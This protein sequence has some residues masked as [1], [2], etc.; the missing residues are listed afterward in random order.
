MPGRDQNSVEDTSELFELIGFLR[1]HGVKA[2]IVFIHHLAKTGQVR[3]STN[4]EAEVD[5]VLGVQ[6]DKTGNVWL[7]IRRARSMDEEIDY[8][9]QF[10][11]RYLGETKQGHKLHAPVVRLVNDAPQK[12]GVSAAMAKRYSDAMDALVKLGVGAHSLE[13]IVLAL[14]NVISVPAPS[15]KQRKNYRTRAVQDAIDS[16]FLDK[17]NWSYGNYILRLSRDNDGF[18][19]TLK[20]LEA[21]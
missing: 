2:T 18:I 21:K 13:D 9:F 14:V 1:S 5:L 7:N 3:G 20:I 19:S 17:L 4:I 11:S 12:A 15:G 6:K 16:I 8:C 10:E